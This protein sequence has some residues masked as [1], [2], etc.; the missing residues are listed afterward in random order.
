MREYRCPRERPLGRK[1]CDCE[2]SQIKLL[3]WSNV[4]VIEPDKLQYFR[5]Y[6]SPFKGITKDAV[7]TFV[8]S[9]EGETMIVTDKSFEASVTYLPKELSAK[10]TTNSREPDWS[11][12]YLDAHVDPV[13]GFTYLNRPLWPCRVKTKSVGPCRNHR[14][15]MAKLKEKFYGMIKFL[16]REEVP[17]LDRQLDDLCKNETTKRFTINA[18][19]E[20]CDVKFDGVFD[21]PTNKAECLRLLQLYA[22]YYNLMDDIAEK[23]LTA[24]D[25]SFKNICDAI[26][27]TKI[28]MF[29]SPLLKLK[30]AKDDKDEIKKILKN[31]GVKDIEVKQ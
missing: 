27:R 7:L 24:K 4:H 28:G 23:K 26:T 2:L 25:M 8:E 3:N 14:P 11:V 20:M 13:N 17:F 15:V 21:D 30:A 18:G 29:G 31:M 5:M 10:I 12:F 9:G 16:P 6:L 1:Y 19:I 22:V